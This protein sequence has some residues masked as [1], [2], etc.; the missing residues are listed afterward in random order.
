MAKR[1]VLAFDYGASSGRAMIG[2]FDGKKVEL[3][4][5]HR[6]LNEPVTVQGSMYWDILRLFHECKQG[7]LKADALGGADAMG[8]DT[9]GVDVGFL[10]K[11]GQLLANPYHYRDAHTASAVEELEKVLPKKELY[12][13]TGLAFQ[14]FNTL[15]QLVVMKNN[16]NLALKNADKMLFIP[17]LFNY[18][19]TGVAATEFTIAST[20][21]MIVPGKTEWAKDVLSAYG[22]RTDMLTEILP[23]ASRLGMLSEGVMS[24]LGLKKNMPVVNVPEH[25]TAS[26]FVSVPAKAGENAAFLSSGTWS[27]LGTELDQPVLT[28]EALLS[29]YTNEGGIGCNIR[30]LKNIMGL[31]IIQECK[32][33]WDKN[34]EVL[35]FAEIAEGASKVPACKFLM[36]PDA[37]EFFSPFEMPL[38]IQKYC[39]AHGL[40]VPESKA[41][42]ARCIYDSLALDYKHNILALEKITGKKVDVLHIV[43]GG[44]NNV[45]L[46]QATADATGLTVTAGPSEGTALGNILTQLIS[47]G[48]LSSLSEARE[49]VRNSTD[50]KEYLPKN[51]AVY[52]AA[53]EKFLKLL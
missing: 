26:A 19:L 51:A 7:I 47:L 18:F 4:E 39:A 34:G 49:V 41:E 50:I 12:A 27:L 32:R 17:D 43:G 1:K 24:E 45:M 15:C 2:A 8:I 10:G 37:D 40:P 35:S 20:S 33:Y 28:E 9:W 44:S 42:I 52:D 22:I 29:G 21:Q 30:F 11:N 38:K 3:T 13:K 6:F 23:T 5:I 16:G 14:K 48:D 25:D 53:Y 46:N 36:N 31:W